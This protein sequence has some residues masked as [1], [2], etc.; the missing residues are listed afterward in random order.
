MNSRLV[1]L[2]FSEELV[3]ESGD[4]SDA[5]SSDESGNKT[6]TESNEAISQP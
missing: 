2:R 6:E 1:S 4:E 3:D 5:Q